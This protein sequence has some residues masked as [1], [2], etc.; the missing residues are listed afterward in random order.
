MEVSDVL[1]AKPPFPETST[2][3]FNKT[4]ERQLWALGHA[5]D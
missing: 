5:K 2:H 4:N 1:H 3:R